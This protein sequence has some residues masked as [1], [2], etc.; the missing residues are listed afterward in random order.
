MVCINVAINGAKCPI[1]LHL[2]LVGNQ[3]L[4]IETLPPYKGIMAALKFN[5]KIIWHKYTDIEILG[6]ERFY[7]QNVDAQHVKGFFVFLN[8]IK[9]V[10]V[11]TVID[12][13][14][15]TEDLSDDL[16][17]NYYHAT[18]IID[19]NLSYL[20]SMARM[21]QSGGFQKFLIELLKLKLDHL[22]GNLQ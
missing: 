7:N 12:K 14:R 18:K 22:Q 17:F 21:S 3:R 1:A 20:A 15:I 10:G 8:M 13:I 5:V 19:V 11:H 6:K 9:D 2:S 4:N 16:Y